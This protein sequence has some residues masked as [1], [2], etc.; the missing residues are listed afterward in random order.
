LREISILTFPEISGE[1][2]VR[3]SAILRHLKIVPMCFPGR[4]SNH[5]SNRSASRTLA[6]G[7]TV[8]GVRANS[9]QDFFHEKAR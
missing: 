6:S 4:M 3:A 5:L 7:L 2:S 1:A 8:T 9:E